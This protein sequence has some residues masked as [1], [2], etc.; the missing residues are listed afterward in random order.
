MTYKK[1]SDL[2][3]EYILSVQGLDTIV[4]EPKDVNYSSECVKNFNYLRHVGRI[5]TSKLVSI[6]DGLIVSD[7]S[8]DLC[9][10]IKKARRLDKANA[11]INLNN[12]LPVYSNDRNNYVLQFYQ[13]EFEKK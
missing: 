10:K 4:Y 8:E 13:I 11:V 9:S 7:N 3:I 1:F 6:K 5:D 12:N 2:G